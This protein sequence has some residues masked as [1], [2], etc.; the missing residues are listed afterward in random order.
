MHCMPNLDHLRVELQ[1]VSF[2][3]KLSPSHISLNA[4]TKEIVAYEKENNETHAVK[5]L[6]ALC[7]PESFVTH[8][9]L[10]T[11]CGT[12]YYI[13]KVF[14]D[15][16]LVRGNVYD[17]VD[18]C[19]VAYMKIHN[20]E[21]ECEEFKHMSKRER[22]LTYLEQGFI[23]KAASMNIG[24]TRAHHLVTGIKGSYLLVHAI[25]N[26]MKCVTIAAGLLKNETTKSYIW[27]LKAFMKAFGKAHSIVVT[28]QDGAMRN[29]ID[30]EFGGSKHRL[31]MWH[32]TQKLPAKMA[33]E[34]EAGIQ[35]TQKGFEFM[36]AA[37]TYEEIEKVTANCNLQDTLQ[38]ASTSSTQSDRALI[39]DSDGSAEMAQEEEA[40]IQS[41]Q[42]G[43]EF[44]AAADTYEEIEKV[45]ANCNLQDTLQQASTSSTQSD[46]ALIYDSDGSAEVSQNIIQNPRV[47]N[48]GTQ[49]GLIGV[50][51]NTNQNLNRN[52]NLVATRADGMT[53]ETHNW[54]SS[55]HQ[56]LY[57]IIK[58][59]NFPI[60][61]QVDARLQNFEIQF[62]KE[63]AKFVGDFKSLA[64]HKALELEIE[65]LLKAVVSQDIM[66]VVQNNY[67]GETLNLQTELERTKERFENYIIK[68][69]N[70]YA[71]LWNDWFLITK[72][73]TS[74]NTKFAKQSILGKPP[75]VGEIHA[76]SKI[77]TS[78]SI[79]T[80][81]ESKV[82]KNNKVIAPG[83]FR[84]N[85][86]KPSREYKH[87]PNNV[88]T[89]IRTKPITVSQP[90][91]I[92]KKVV[93][94]DSNGLS[95]IGVDNTKTRRPQPRSNTKN[96]RVPSVSKSSRSKNKEVKVEVEEHHRKLLMSK[97]TKHMSSECNNVKLATQNVYSKVVCAMCKQCLISVNHDVRLLNYV[98]DMNS[99]GKKQTANVSIKEKQKK[100]KSKVK[101]PKKV[102]SIE[103]LATPKPSKP[104]SFLRRSPT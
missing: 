80:P 56:K 12:I 13:S 70:E 5:K 67:V 21:L 51:G 61:N 11:P 95:S 24:A 29:G 6:D 68:K 41:T 10:D 33:Q 43:F 87:M 4:L 57:K 84:T 71:K 1:C 50:P 89:S 66:S 86:F 34:E 100:Q 64:K 94:S 3:S 38:Q 63:E 42:K 7:T 22:Q 27:L 90:P 8:S 35:S 17:L 91:V 103:R 20:H 30:A 62:L 55:A 23:V 32:I 82:M 96:N 83:M 40:G 54:S 52:G 76:L 78:N 16:L 26:H 58:D 46:R 92:T 69:E 39:Y 49:N 74:V 81:Q 47:Q 88:R 2:L 73:G 93:N 28:D 104:R 14:A 37:D 99:H 45:T 77:V 75:K 44:M 85:P 59:E 53:L 102:G 72:R 98:N 18:D 97:N 79:P 9:N 25:N 48:V 60:V 19:V 31:C 15:V 65:R 101:K 36:A